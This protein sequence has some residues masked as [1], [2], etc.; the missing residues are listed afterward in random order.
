MAIAWVLRDPRM[1]GALIGASRPEQIDDCVKAAADTQFD[2]SELSEVDRYAEN[3]GLN[4]WAESSG[5]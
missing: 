1:S 5:G 4:L 2:E 3:R